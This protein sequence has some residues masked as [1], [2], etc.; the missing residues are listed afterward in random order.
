MSMSRKEETVWQT[1]LRES[2]INPYS[3]FRVKQVVAGTPG[4]TALD[5][6]YNHLSDNLAD[7]LCP[8]LQG[9][10]PLTGTCLFRC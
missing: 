5:L 9:G 6:S 8:I 3:Y 4:L 10:P 1:T 2:I 7:E